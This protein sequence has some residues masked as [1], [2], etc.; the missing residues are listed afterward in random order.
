MTLAHLKDK[1]PHKPSSADPAQAFGAAH[2]TEEELARQRFSTNGAP[3]Q[4]QKSVIDELRSRLSSRSS[5]GP[6]TTETIYANAPEGMVPF[7]DPFGNPVFD[8]SGSPIYVPEGTASASAPKEPQVDYAR[9]SEDAFNRFA[10]LANSMRDVP[11]FSEQPVY[12]PQPYYPDYNAYGAQPVYAPPEYSQPAFYSQPYYAETPPVY[13]QEP[14][15]QEFYPPE[16]SYSQNIEEQPESSLWE[17]DAAPEEKPERDYRVSE[18]NFEPN[19]AEAA[20]P[21]EPEMIQYQTPYGTYFGEQ[22]PEYTDNYAPTAAPPPP[23]NAR[24]PATPKKTRSLT[25]IH[26]ALWGG[27]ILLSIILTAFTF[28][29][30]CAI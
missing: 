14:Y 15:R 28:I 10:G 1:L 19:L 18:P 8:A 13:P 26:Y 9:Q 25:D 30:A 4:E 3:L 29:Y 24:K 2:Q 23:M 6:L 16:E 5:A 27:A 17:D 12:A 21:D 11:E 22:P 7:L 20:E